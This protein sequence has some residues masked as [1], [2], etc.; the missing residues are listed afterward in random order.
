M[1]KN[2]GKKNK[3]LKISAQDLKK[4][5]LTLEDSV[6]TSAM[7]TTTDTIDTNDT[8]SSNGEILLRLESKLETV[9]KKIDD[10]IRLQE[11]NYEKLCE[12]LKIQEDKVSVA[13][14][15]IEKLS[16]KLNDA[17]Q[18]QGS[19]LRAFKELEDKIEHLEREK[20]KKTILIEGV[21]D[22]PENTPENIIIHLFRDIGLERGIGDIDAFYR[23]GKQPEANSKPRPIV[24]S[25]IRLSDKIQLFRNLHKLKNNKDWKFVYINDDLTE[26]QMSEVRDLKAVNALA[27]SHGANSFMK[28]NQLILE[29]QKYN[30]N[31][32]DKLPENFTMEKAKNRLVDGDKGLA[33]QGHHSVLSNMA[34]CNLIYNGNSFSSSEA[35][36]QHEKAKICGSRKEISDILTAGAYKAKSIGK[37]IKNSKEWDSKKME[38]VYDITKEKFMQNDNML[39][40]L[41]A[42]SDLRLYEATP[43]NYWGCGLSMA[44]LNEIRE[45]K[46]PGS[47]KFGQIL[48]KVRSDLKKN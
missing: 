26:K 45:G 29:G 9:N 5:E 24:V 44:R 6:K 17:E 47:N 42:T 36:I 23:R 30:Q 20:R 2:N 46:I 14:E 33:F 18:K 4:T 16:K 1:T 37:G 34:E 31:N 3:N 11:F 32:M 12:K 39:D 41:M 15:K 28:G 25:F 7:A 21:K 27:R 35:A 38:I 40:R 43:S 8:K 13:N 48:E 10:S 22:T 19:Q